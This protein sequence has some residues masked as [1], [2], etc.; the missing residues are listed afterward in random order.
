MSEEETLSHA[1]ARERLMDAVD[2]IYDVQEYYG[3]L[4]DEEQEMLKDFK[5]ST[6]AVHFHTG[7][8]EVVFDL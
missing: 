2:A 6:A 8:G 7:D 3:D 5:S 4:T 1:D